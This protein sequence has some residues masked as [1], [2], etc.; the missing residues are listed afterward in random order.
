MAPKTVNYRLWLPRWKDLPS[1]LQNVCKSYWKIKVQ[2]PIVVLTDGHSSRYDTDGKKFCRKED[3]NSWVSLTQL[4]CHNSLIKF[5]QTYTLA[6]QMERPSFWWWESKSRGIHADTC[7]YLGCLNNKRVTYKSGKTSW[8]H[9]FWYQYKWH[10]KRQIYQKR[11]CDTTNTNI[12][13]GPKEYW[14]QKC[15]NYKVKCNELIKTL[16][17][18]DDIPGLLT[19]QK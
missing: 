3:I 19:V 9:F 8:N 5:F 6:I 2:K 13:H 14:H 16:I 17:S 12:R 18:P 4:S 11:G 1:E 10:A 15:E 7:H